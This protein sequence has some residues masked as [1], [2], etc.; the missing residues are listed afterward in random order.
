[1]IDDANNPHE[2]A[3]VIAV[4][5]QQNQPLILV[6]LPTYNGQTYLAEQI[7]S[8]LAQTHQHVLLVCRDDG[9]TDESDAI[10]ACY[11]QK[12]PA[13]VLHMQDEL[14]NL[15]AAASF[16]KLMSWALGHCSEHKDGC[17]VYVALT[18]QDDIWHPERLENCLERMRREQS[19]SADLPLLVHSDLR[20]VNSDG[21][22]TASSFMK[23]QG[24]NPQRTSL[25]AQLL[26]NT[27]T[28]CTSLMNLPLLRQALPIP[29]EAVMHDWWLSLVASAFGRICYMDQVLVDYRQHGHNTIGAK[30]FVGPG[31]NRITLRKVFMRHL[32]AETRALFTDV[33]AQADAFYKRFNTQLS[34][35]QRWI[36]RQVCRLPDSGVWR[37]R[38][39]SRVLRRI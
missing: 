11:A 9:S 15:G 26:S 5:E 22:E 29:R 19:D 8:I 38:I 23:F 25:A 20:V 18:D 37:L 28:G 6:L 4:S 3:S 30:A 13:R 24:L 16:S 21:E 33:A 36:I 39:V 14:G 32:P 31:L 27:V 34:C 35:R 1:V 2:Q 12:F 7:D 10:L 17:S